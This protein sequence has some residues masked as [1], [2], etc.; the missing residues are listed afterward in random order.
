[1]R[2]QQRNL[3]PPKM[4]RDRSP[5]HSQRGPPCSNTGEQGRCEEI[6]DGDPGGGGDLD[7]TSRGVLVSLDGLPSAEGERESAWYLFCPPSMASEGRGINPNQR[8][9]RKEECKM[10]ISVE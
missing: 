10:V 9:R 8:K 1:M 3:L 5:E 6:S 2:Y 7:G 4:K